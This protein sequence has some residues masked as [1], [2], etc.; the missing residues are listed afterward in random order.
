RTRAPR[1][2]FL[3]SA[4]VRERDEASCCGRFDEQTDL[5]RSV[6][7]NGDKVQTDGSLHWSKRESSTYE[8]CD[9]KR[10]ASRFACSFAPFPL[11]GASTAGGLH[12]GVLRRSVNEA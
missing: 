7:L 5:S 12:H 11:V 2:W 10:G 4:P 1:S 6:P 3:A 9:Y 8:S